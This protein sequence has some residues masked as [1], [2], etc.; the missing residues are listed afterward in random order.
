MDHRTE[1]CDVYVEICGDTEKAICVDGGPPAIWLPRS[2]IDPDESELDREAC[3]MGD[4][5]HIT[6]PCWLAEQKGLV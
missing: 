6:I 5:G 3:T 1:T 2:Q 4:A